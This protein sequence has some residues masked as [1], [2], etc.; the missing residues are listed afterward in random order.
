MS[1]NVRF[2]VVFW[3]SARGCGGDMEMLV[4]VVN[5][6][7]RDSLI[8]GNDDEEAAKIYGSA[9]VCVWTRMDESVAGDYGPD[10]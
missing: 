9:M 1:N 6:K 10:E 4:P 2:V 5:S 8:Q 3:L 7:R